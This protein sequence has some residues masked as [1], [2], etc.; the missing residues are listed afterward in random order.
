MMGLPQYTLLMDTVSHNCSVALAREGV[1]CAS[2]SINEAHIH[3]RKLGVL[4]QQV[5]D[6]EGIK[7]A[8]LGTIALGRGPGS[9]TGLRIGVATAKSMAF[10]LD[11]PL[12]GINS[13]ASMAAQTVDQAE[14]TDA[15][16]APML[17]ARRM[18][19]Y[20]ATFDNQLNLYAETESHVI[21]EDSFRALLKDQIV[22]F[23]GNGMSKARPYLEV[24]SNARFVYDIWPSAHFMVQE[25]MRKWEKGEVE[26]VSTFEP[27][28]LKAFQANSGNKI[29]KVLKS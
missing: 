10:A 18:E 15:L 17:D 2:K 22:Y 14:G 27:F 24:N 8:S 23:S 11:I 25:A 26:E 16:H 29:Q 3:S 12:I 7:A 5:L 20:T 19:I 13:L 28:Y 6:Q 21:E 1:I 4:I 9:Y